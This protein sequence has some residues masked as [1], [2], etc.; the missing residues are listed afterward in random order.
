MKLL[1]EDIVA[2]EKLLL[3]NEVSFAAKGLYAYLLLRSNLEEVNSTGVAMTMRT[4]EQTIIS[5]L[6]ELEAKGYI[7]DSGV[8][9]V[10]APAK[11]DKRDPNITALVEYFES[12]MDLK[13]PKSQ[14]Q[15]YAAK[16][17]LQRHKLEELKPA[18]DLV[19]ACRYERFCPR[20]LSLMD[21]R[22]KWDALADF[23]RRNGANVKKQMEARDR[24]ER[25]T[26]VKR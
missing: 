4:D 15:R 13:M 23:Y 22:D 1:H 17:L 24:I 9:H 3:D 12:K 19:A 16:T 25:M 6:R 18:I 26:G 10:L 8:G 2:P 7:A 20:I 11:P 21:L 14:Y 5:A